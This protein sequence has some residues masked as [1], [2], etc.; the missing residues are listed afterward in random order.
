[1]YSGSASPGTQ[2]APR[3]RRPTTASSSPPPERRPQ[4][5]RSAAGAPGREPARAPSRSGAKQEPPKPIPACRNFGPMRSSRPMPRATSTTSAPVSSHTLAISL[6]N[7]IFVARNAFEASLTI[8]AR[9]DVGADDRGVERRVERLDRVAGPVAAVAD[10]DAV[11]LQEV[12]DRRALLEELRA[13]HVAEALAPAPRRRARCSRRCRPARSTSSPARG[14]RTPA[15]RRRR[16]A[17]RTGRRRPS[18]S[19][20][21]RRRRTAAARARAP[22]ARSVEKCSRSRCSAISSASPGSQIGIR[23]SCEPAHLLGVDVDAVDVR[24]ERGEAGRR[25]EPDVAGADHAD[26]RPVGG[27]AAHRRSARVY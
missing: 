23:P 20:A 3:D 1:M 18:R 21:C 10:H 26:R 13:R 6:M 17:R 9:L 16:R 4:L 2:R 12:L 11:G 15:S 19:A 27:R 5:R 14:G 24:A 22:G 25:D 7:E 8:S